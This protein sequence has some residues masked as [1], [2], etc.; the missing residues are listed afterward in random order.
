MGVRPAG[1]PS[2]RTGIPNGTELIRMATGGMS[3]AEAS[4]EEG[5]VGLDGGVAIWVGEG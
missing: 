2:T 1:V 3:G 4:S 5:P